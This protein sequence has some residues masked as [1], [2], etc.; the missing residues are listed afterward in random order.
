MLRTLQRRDV[1]TYR[2]LYRENFPEEAEVLRTDDAAFARIVARL[3]QPQI[4][5]LLGLLRSIGRPIGHFFAVEADGKLVGTTFL[6]FEG[7]AGYIASVVVDT[8]YRGRGYAKEMM[9]AAEAA[10]RRRGKAH[11]VL[12]VIA[13]NQGARALYD[14][15]GYREIRRVT[16]YTRDVG[17]GL[18]PLPAAPTGPWAERVRPFRNPDGDR[19]A[20][21]ARAR[22]PPEDRAVRPVGPRAFRVPPLVAQALG[23]E[24]AAFVL[25]QDGRPMGFV[26]GSTGSAMGSANLV[27]PVLDPS[28]PEEGGLALLDGGLAWLAERSVA[29]IVCEVPDDDTAAIARLSSR[30]FVPALRLETLAKRV[31]P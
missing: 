28:L 31:G 4:R 30:G 22:Q 13:T 1:E 21:I 5:L 20:E 10:T 12:D 18:P 17:P 9:A 25:E 29:R 7:Q 8:P 14:K 19:L 24:S 27:A 16:W 26:R 15:L 2:R 3:F 6:F 11:A 23:A